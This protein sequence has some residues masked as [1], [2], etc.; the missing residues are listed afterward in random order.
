[1]SSVE[2]DVCFP[3]PN[4]KEE[5]GIDYEY[6]EEYLLVERK[7]LSEQRSRGDYRRTLSDNHR[8][9]S[10]YGDRLMVMLLIFVY[11]ILILV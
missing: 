3:T 1:M 6:L 7:E 9:F 11:S 10:M 8:R 4:K 2:V 5:G